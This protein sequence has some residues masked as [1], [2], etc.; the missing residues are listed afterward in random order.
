MYTEKYRVKI[1]QF[2]CTSSS[3]VTY[4]YVEQYIL[5]YIIY[6]VTTHAHLCC[7]HGTSVHHSAMLLWY[8]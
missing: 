4:S 3:I 2:V 7:V 8:E 1:K 6:T 5:L